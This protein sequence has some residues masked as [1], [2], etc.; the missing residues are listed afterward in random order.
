MST[1]DVK[2]TRE[3]IQ[4]KYSYRIQQRFG[5][6]K[7]GILYEDWPIFSTLYFPG[8]FGFSTFISIVQ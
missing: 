5:L 8:S 2:K 6:L 3:R 7:R 1:K 4:G